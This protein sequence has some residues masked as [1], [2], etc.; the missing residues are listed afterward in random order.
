MTGWGWTKTEIGFLVRGA[1]QLYPATQRPGGR[2]EVAIVEQ[3]VGKPA[4]QSAP[5]VPRD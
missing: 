3:L 1:S 5:S 4:L 2:A